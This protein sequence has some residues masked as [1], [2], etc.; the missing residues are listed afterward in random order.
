[1]IPF[2]LSV[3]SS[4]II[5]VIFRMF[6]RFKVDTFQAIVFNYFTAAGIGFA[7]FGD[8]WNN[9]A[10][11]QNSWM[12]YSLITSFLFISLFFLMGLSSQGN[13]VASTSVAVKMSMAISIILLVIYYSE[14]PS[15]AKVT[16]IILAFISVILVSLPNKKNKSLNNHKWMLIVLFIG[17]GALDFVLN[18]VQENQ[19]NILEPSL[20]SAISF[21]I[22]GCIGVII[23]SVKLL[24]GNTKIA[25]KNV[26][27][28]IVLGVP[29]FFSIYFLLLAY[30]TTGWT[31][32]TVLALTNVSVVIGTV[33]IGLIIFKE[34]KT[35]K[36]ML[37]LAI[38]LLAIV[39]L[40]FAEQ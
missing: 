34:S 30:R 25:F 11:E 33:I 18:Y 35:S 14:S 31:D 13:G 17:G 7:F 12:T 37:G 32:T 23:L 15:L 8:S 5:F 1:M 22:A 4:T 26:I 10:W 16:G 19:L 20:F 28:G 29:N 21:G 39:T 38:A 6:K 36:K 9:L 2:I 24:K 27:G 3:L 40:Y